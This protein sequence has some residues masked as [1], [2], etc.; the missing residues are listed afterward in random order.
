MI[1]YIIWSVQGSLT[2]ADPRS[3]GITLLHAK[4]FIVD[5]WSEINNMYKHLYKDRL[6]NQLLLL[7]MNLYRHCM[8]DASFTTYT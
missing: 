1:L 7:N 6:I 2:L 5:E 4:S 8:F 3:R